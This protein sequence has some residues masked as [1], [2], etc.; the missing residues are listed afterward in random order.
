LGPDDLVGE[1]RGEIETDEGVLV[2]KRIHVRY[3]L[4]VSESDREAVERAH[5][6][7]VESCPVARTLMPCVD[8]ETEVVSNLPL[9]N[10]R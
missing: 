4:R 1:V 2:I 8:I 7:H 3:V 6:V 9:S 5:R 10:D